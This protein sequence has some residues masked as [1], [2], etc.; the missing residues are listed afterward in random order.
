MT[1]PTYADRLRAFAE[2]AP[3][4][5]MVAIEHKEGGT[6]NHGEVIYVGERTYCDCCGNK[7]LKRLSPLRS[8]AGHTYFVGLDCHANLKERGLIRWEQWREPEYHFGEGEASR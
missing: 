7:R 5:Q 6:V 4:E 1:K 8:A 2:A 3:F